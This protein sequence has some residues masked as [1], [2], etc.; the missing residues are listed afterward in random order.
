VNK[1]TI[2]AGTNGAGIFTLGNAV[3]SGTINVGASFNFGT[4]GMIALGDNLQLTNT[5]AITGS[6]LTP[7]MI[8]LGNNGMLANSGTIAVGDFG[9]GLIA[10]AAM[11]ASPTAE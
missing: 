4:G 8:I 1:G 11:R 3:N 10:T 7:A 9:G 6:A 5:G 2:T